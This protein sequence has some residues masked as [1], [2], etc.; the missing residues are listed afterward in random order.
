LR[1]LLYFDDFV[2]GQR[3]SHP[4][5]P[6]MT[7]ERIKTFAAEFDPQPFHLDEEAAASHPIFA[8]LAASGWHTAATTARL[9][10]ESVPFANGLVGL[11]VEVSWPRPTR[12]GD[13]LSVTTEVIALTSSRSKP[14]RGIVT[15]RTETRNQHDD[16]LQVVTT[17]VMVP[18]RP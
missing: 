12:A 1:S 3:F 15:I 8:G 13:R 17:K 10:V 6:V 14:D 11:G 16:V 18:R 4:E 7:L 5:H 9:L 2:V